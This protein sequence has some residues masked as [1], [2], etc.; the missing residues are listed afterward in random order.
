MGER[1]SNADL[2]DPPAEAGSR[3][4]WYQFRLWHLFALVTVAAIGCSW[5]VCKRNAA[6]RQK[7]AV[8]R[9]KELGAY[10]WY[11]YVASTQWEH[12]ADP[13]GPAWFRDLV[14]VDFLA[15]VVAVDFCAFGFQPQVTD[16]DLENLRGMTKLEY[17]DLSGTQV[18]D[19]GL[20][21]LRGMTQLEELYLYGTE[22]SDAG[23]EKL[24][25]ALPNCRIYH[26]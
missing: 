6:N 3:L 4:R 24:R 2:K 11:D 23:A 10:V 22:V 20:E 1:D 17:L 7:A 25:Q 9:V 15:D 21:R 8:E 5:F 14:G 12:K 18:S 26:D 13:P 19:A 16:A